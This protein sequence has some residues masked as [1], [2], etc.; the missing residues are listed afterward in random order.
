M[1][2]VRTSN[3]PAQ[4][5]L[6]VACDHCGLP[7]PRGLVDPAA[8]EQF[9]CHGCRTVFEMIHSHGLTDYY[10][11]RETVD[12]PHKAA[13]TSGE[14]YEA[15]DS[16]AFTAKHCRPVSGDYRSVDLRLEG[17]HCAACMWLVERLPQLVPGV[18]SARLN[19]RDA[20]VRVTWN[21]ELA[22]LSAI[23]T[24]LDRLGYPAIRRRT[25]RPAKS[26]ARTNERN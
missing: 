24:T 18:A 26:T 9:C 21:P 6:P 20:V 14:R 22:K 4:P 16:P 15:F 23:A 10:R 7:V 2:A 1:T 11:V 12:A 25:P 5:A 17:I 3:P 19:Q 13:R 8:T